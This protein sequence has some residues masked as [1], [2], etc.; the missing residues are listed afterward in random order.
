MLAWGLIGFFAGALALALK[1]SKIVLYAYGVSAAIAFSMIMDVWSAIWMAGEFS[2]EIYAAKLLTSV[3]H[4]LIYAA[5]NVIFLVFFAKPFS[6]KLE[7]IHIKY[8][9]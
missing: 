1:R 6:E 4:T 2:L 7:R 3:P 8:G 5:S 9:I